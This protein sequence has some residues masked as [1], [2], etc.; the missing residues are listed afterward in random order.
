[1]HEFLSIATH[2][3]I[4]SPPTSLRAA[5][6]HVVAWLEAPSLTLL[7]EGSGYWPVLLAILDQSRV[8][9]R[10]VH[11]AHM[12][13][14]CLHHGVSELWTADRDFRR[15]HGLNVVNPLIDA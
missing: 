14:L 10:R 12:A 9:G 8:T 15:F 13:T 11:D 6:E 4:C 3:R 5:I 7:G 1:V 2:P